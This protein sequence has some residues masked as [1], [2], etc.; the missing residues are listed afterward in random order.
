[1]KKEEN[2]E[3]SKEDNFEPINSEKN[4]HRLG[5]ITIF[6]IFGLLGGWAVLAQIETSVGASGKV[7]SQGYKKVVQHPTGGVVTKIFVQ[8]GDEVQKGS[9]ILNL[10]DITVSSKLSNAI[11]QYDNELIKMVRLKAES[12]L[13]KSINFD[14]IRGK[15]IKIDSCNSLRVQAN[16]LFMSNIETLKIGT[17]LL[18]DK[19]RILKEQ[20]TGLRMA[21][22]SNKKQLH[23]YKK[24]LNKWRNLYKRNMTDELKLLD[25][26]R[27]IEQIK[28]AIVQAESKIKEN[29]A[30]IEANKNQIKFEKSRF[31]N[32]ANKELDETIQKIVSLR[33]EI[34]SLR[35]SKERL[36]VKS[37]DNGIIV[38]MTIHA[39][40]EVV[41]PRKP[42]AYVVPK[43]SEL[44]IEAFIN[45]TDID[46]VRKGQLADIVFPSYVDPG[47]K[48]VEGNLTYVSADTIIPEGEK[49]PFYK[50][51]VKITPKGDEAIKSNGFEIV[52]GMPASVIIKAGKRSFMS[53]ILLPLESLFKGAFHAN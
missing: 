50:A 9:S 14:E 2:R 27:K 40:G 16:R 36:V 20:I 17:D 15:V 33:E 5:W 30:T 48:P 32:Q 29:L 3:E 6:V 46:K 19:N 39:E 11:S 25:R 10:D 4:P 49:T 22:K 53:Y 23:S 7:I 18:K 35:N 31:K 8:D 28:L 38:D 13:S 44:I 47:A 43:E 51:L 45:P 42:I 37:P 41:T 24:E 1:M 21:I 52:P 34:K 12:N 26:E